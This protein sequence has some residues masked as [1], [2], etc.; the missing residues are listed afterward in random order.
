M[1]IGPGIFGGYSGSLS[2]TV[3]YSF[4]NYSGFSQPYFYNSS[5]VS[6][7]SLTGADPVNMADGTFQVQA[8]DLSVGD[9]EPRGLSFSHYYSSS[10]RNSHLAGMAPGWLHNYYMNAATVSSPQAG[11]GGTTPA[12]M[13]T[14]LVA[15]EAA[16]SIYNR[17]QPDPKNWLT[18]ALIAK[19]GIDQLTAKAVSVSLG[20]DTIQFI[21]QPD[22]SFTPPANSTMMLTQATNG[23][24]TL[25]ERHGRTFTFDK[26]GWATNIAD[27][28]GKSLT[29]AYNASNWVTTATD[30]KGRALTFNY[31]TTS[32][33]RL[34]SV[35]DGGGRS[36]ALGYSTGGDLISVTDPESKTNRFLYDTN[37]QITANFDA[38]NQLVASNI[39][40]SFGR[41]T[42]QFTQGDT[43]KTWRIF[44]SGWQTVSQ[45]PA[46]GKQ[47]YFYD[48]KTRVIAQQDQLGNVSRSVFDGQDHVIASVSPLNETNQFIFDGNHNVVQVI[49]PL[50]FSNQF[51]YDGQNNL[52][53]ALDAL[54]NPTTFGYNSKF[55]M[56]GQTN[57]AGDWISFGFDSDDGALTS[58]T[59]EGGATTYGYD[60]IYRRL[61]NVAYPNG[62]GSESFANS[63]FGDVTNHTDARGFSTAYQYNARRQLTNTIAPTNLTVKVTYD[64]VGNQLATTDARGLTYS[65]T[66]SPTRRLVAAKFPTTASGAA[67]IT[68][69]YDS[70][71]WLVKT[72]DSYQQPVLYS[73]DLAGRLVSQT[74]PLQRTTAFGFDAN[75]KTIATTNAEQ[76]IT[77][78]TWDAR[79]KPIQQVDG[80]Q[81]LSF[82]FFDPAGNQTV[83]TNRNGKTW[84]FQF[85]GANRVTATTTPLNR[86]RTQTYNHLGLPATVTDP[87]NQTTILFYDSKHRLTNRTDNL[88]AIFYSYDANDNGTNVIENGKTNSWA[89]DAYNR[90]STYQD[91]NGFLLQYRYDL[92]GNLTNLIY[93]GNKVVAYF[94]DS[95]NRLTNVTDWSQRKTVITYDLA[96]RIT[97]LVRP[98]GTYQTDNY[99]AAGEVTNILD[100]M[101]NTLPIA[102]F[103]FNWTN[104]GSLGWEFSAPL[105]HV[106][107][108][109][110]RTMTYDD[111]NQM[112]TVNNQAV[113]ADANGNLTNAPLP[114]GNFASL[115]FDARNRLLIT[116]GVTNTYD[117]L[118]NRIGQKSGTNSSVFVVNPNA[119]LPQ[120][121]MRIKNGVT[122]YYIYGAGLIYQITETATA[123]NTRSYH[124]D[125]RGSTV[126]IT[127]D[128][129]NATDRIEYSA[130]GLTTYSRKTTDTPFL[131]NGKYGVMTDTNG[132]LY[133][134]ARYYNPYLCR[135]MS[136]DPSGF[137]GGLNEYAYAS[138]NPVALVDPF[139]LG[140]M[141]SSVDLSWFN[142]PTAGEQAFHQFLTDFANL[143]TF[144]LANDVARVTSGLAD[145]HGIGHDLYGNVATRQDQYLSGAMLAAAVIPFG[146]LESSSSRVA[147]RVGEGITADTRMITVL[148]SS[149][150]VAPYANRPGFNVL[151]MNNLPKSEWPRQNALWL[152][153]AIRRGDTIWL[154]TDP[155]ANSARLTAKYGTDLGSYYHSLELPFLE[156]YSG[157]NVVPRH[158]TTH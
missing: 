134:R 31:S 125:Y 107:T 68:N 81:H 77:R 153:Q 73:N 116:G 101:A 36:I 127:D 151:N 100:Q 143:A 59:D 117:A 115:T 42:T 140:A 136:A 83:L 89:Y 43:N 84:H 103:K 41:V 98:N 25:Q 6:L 123:T 13:A 154:V 10:R 148:G 39:Y 74:D 131:F 53:K 88:G 71:D 9:T 55:Q 18:T 16:I 92:N 106:S 56:T 65:N 141:E 27:Q 3:D 135:F 35:A 95:L 15:T 24:Y 112:L 7:P 12:Q 22:G 58:R 119:S 48:D 105:P 23:A 5:P 149:S 108:A 111:D 142:A 80:A 40:N 146:A 110:T 75:G 72:L 121:L 87:A 64:A 114:N 14:M 21:K 57:G 28:Y 2:A 63:Y 49:D 17:A 29:L 20:Q 130:Y 52:T 132:L 129:G 91:A 122:N 51:I 156:Q 70:R 45:D 26:S 145:D 133:M 102:W 150:D 44:W 96:G 82:A 158:L 67:S 8:T 124:F 86:Q 69:I 126:A 147:T 104:N 46:G 66:W 61:N 97:G 32:P 99:D 94:Y 144:G 50:G 54:G 137:G 113:N 157:I 33:K 93:P 138:G 79:G 60:T 4:V 155:V 152:N 38:L 62:L 1:L 128:S 47:S 19:W 34:I 76:E 85:D 78:Q 118:N 37:H 120:T 109:P 139:G 11:L 30:W 90:I